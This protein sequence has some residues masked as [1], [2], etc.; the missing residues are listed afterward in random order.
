MFN[1][2]NALQGASGP[3][4]RETALLT[5]SYRPAVSSPTPSPAQHPQFVDD[6]TDTPESPRLFRRR[7]DEPALLADAATLAG[8]RRRS[9]GPLGRPDLLHSTAKGRR[10]IARAGSSCSQIRIVRSVADTS[11]RTVYIARLLC[12]NN[13]GPSSLDNTAASSRLAQQP[14][15]LNYPRSPAAASRTRPAHVPFS[16]LAPSA[17][18]SFAFPPSRPSRSADA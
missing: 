13:C 18:R 7:Y 16:R 1:L 11:H 3:F 14:E 9:R 2:D 5:S 10:R 6:R 8:E 4:V 17:T 15:Y 12:S